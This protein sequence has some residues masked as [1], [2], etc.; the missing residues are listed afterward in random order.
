MVCIRRYKDVDKWIAFSFSTNTGIF[1]AFTSRRSTELF[2]CDCMCERVY[3]TLY[4]D[5][6]KWFGIVD[7]DEERLHLTKYTHTH[8][9]YAY[10]HINTHDF[11]V[12]LCVI[13]RTRWERAGW[14]LPKNFVVV[15]VTW[16]TVVIHC[17]PICF[18]LFCQRTCYEHLCKR[19]QGNPNKTVTLHSVCMHC[20][21]N[22]KK[23]KTKEE[24]K[25]KEKALLFRRTNT[26]PLLLLH[27]I[28][29]R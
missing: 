18:A 19:G 7:D 4:T 6:D 20:T 11:D 3:S 17:T 5:M 22:A 21:A 14:M 10:T 28:N 27:S 15:V 12:G 9:H 16:C 26:S 29:M 23:K 2:K 8:T 13:R 24:K 1:R 25:R